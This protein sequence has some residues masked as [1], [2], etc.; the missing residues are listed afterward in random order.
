MLRTLPVVRRLRIR[1][2]GEAQI[3][4]RGRGV[5]KGMEINPR[6]GALDISYVQF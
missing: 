1:T 6:T 3:L 4:R 2:D 5:P